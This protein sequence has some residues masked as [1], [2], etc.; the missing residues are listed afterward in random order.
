L[1]KT[2]VHLVT[3]INQ[4]ADLATDN[5]ASGNV[6]TLIA[7]LRVLYENYS[8]ELA[9]A[10][11]DNYYEFSEAEM[12]QDSL[13]TTANSLKLE[14]QK[15]GEQAYV[16]LSRILTFHIYRRLL[17]GEINP[18]FELIT[19]AAANENLATLMV[20][21]E[22]FKTITSN[23]T[24]TKKKL[25]GVVG[26]ES[27]NVR[28]INIKPKCNDTVSFVFRYVDAFG[29]VV[30][31]DTLEG[32]NVD[33]IFAVKEKAL[34]SWIL[35]KQ[36]QRTC[37]LPSN[38]RVPVTYNGGPVMFTIDNNNIY[39]PSVDYINSTYLPEWRNEV[40]KS[41]RIFYDKG[42]AAFFAIN[43]KLY[44]P[45][46]TR[47]I[48]VTA[49][50][51]NNSS[52]LGLSPDIGQNK[53]DSDLLRGEHLNFPPKFFSA[54]NPKTGLA[55]M[56][57]CLY[58]NEFKRTARYPNYYI[59]RYH[60]WSELKKLNYVNPNAYFEGG[61]SVADN[62]DLTF[63]YYNYNPPTREAIEVLNAVVRASATGASIDPQGLPPNPSYPK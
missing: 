60:V 30:A 48:E 1:L 39:S 22:S 3:N 40:A 35:G 63:G 47:S 18:R 34:L 45:R 44:I 28:R 5:L 10:P 27:R 52:A 25:D 12:L 11:P 37:Q 15:L 53:Y 9:Q 23:N 42:A 2:I 7:P 58:D 14:P 20:D 19:A 62:G 59:P 26:G 16:Y 49:K 41:N 8:E 21:F 36:I 13:Y 51:L 43:K 33:D 55:H 38:R 24:L 31:E 61:R 57:L 4:P 46:G 32:P 50:F 54:N 29:I 17:N 56:K 6:A